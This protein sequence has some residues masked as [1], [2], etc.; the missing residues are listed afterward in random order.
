MAL[1]LNT[2]HPLYASLV[3]LIC[4][5]D[6]NTV[7][8]LKGDICTPDASVVIGSGIY[9]RHFRTKVVSN[10]A[11][12]VALTAG[13]ATKPVATPLGTS[14]IVINAGNSR[15]S[16][17]I[18][19]NGTATSCVGPAVFTGD[20]AGIHPGGSANPQYL[21]TTDI[22]GTGA[23]SFGEAHNGT[24]G[25]IENKTFVDGVVE[26]A[27]TT[28]VGNANDGYKCTYIGGASAGGYGGFAAD[29]VWIAHFRRVLSDAEIAD[30]HASLGTGN[31]FA[32]VGS[33]TGESD[34]TGTGTPASITLSA[35]TG[36]AAGTGGATNGTGTGTLQSVILTAP[37]GTAT[38]TSASAG[39]ITTPVLKNNTGMILA[40]E[41]GVTV[42][43]YNSST[44]AL[45]V[46]KTGQTSNASGIV[47]ISDALIVPATT[48]AYEVILT[49]SRRR[50]PIA[51]AV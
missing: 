4:V 13:F 16:R 38:G 19:F 35:P 34:A 49:G 7:K 6:D 51:S 23:H 36:S 42:N 30:L 14:F 25:Q 31:K 29:Y 50:L 12:G 33:G 5:D 43:V 45:I 32:L 10:N 18:V 8:D 40:N 22:I 46:Q 27:S 47:T 44:G 41:T 15:V 21:G 24:T 17:G 37:A 39:T 11:F 2:S 28:N 9:G 20:C 48:Y 1:S 3:A 26:Q